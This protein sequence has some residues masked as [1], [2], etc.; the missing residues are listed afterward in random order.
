[1]DNHRI[2][3]LSDMQFGL[4]KVKDYIGSDKFGR[5]LWECECECGNTRIVPG[6]LLRKGITKS[7]G[8]KIHKLRLNHFKTHGDTNTRLYRIYAGMKSRCYNK[9]DTGYH[10]YGERGIQ[11]CNEWLN[12]YE[13][14]KKWA[15]SHG[16][17]DTLTIDRK[18]VNGDYCPENCKW[19]TSE[20]Q[21]NNKRNN[22]YIEID[23]VSHTIAE[24]SRIKNISD[25]TIR[26]RIGLGWNEDDAVTIPL[27]RK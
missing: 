5:A 19:I 2:K 20:A 15:L 9:N 18:N 17:N 1:M 12:S 10:L 8:N 22:H 3:D 24:W 7:C 13:S 11:I 16:Y 14:F 26:R 25:R 23:G 27:K 6:E 21:A 4:L